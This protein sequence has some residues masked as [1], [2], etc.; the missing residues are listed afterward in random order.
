ML[1]NTQL[2]RVVND[3]E[4]GMT[5]K[6]PVLAGRDLAELRMTV[7]AGKEQQMHIGTDRY[8]RTA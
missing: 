5:V 4:A 2:L 6:I 7:E 3:D 1:D 8:R